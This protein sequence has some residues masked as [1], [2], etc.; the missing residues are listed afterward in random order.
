MADW[1]LGI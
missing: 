1:G